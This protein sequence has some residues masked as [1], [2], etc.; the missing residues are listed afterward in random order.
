MIEI[1]HMM[2]DPFSPVPSRNSRFFFDTSGCCHTF[3]FGGCSRVL[4]SC[5]GLGPYIY[6][7]FL[8]V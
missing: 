3:R 8:R 6:I 4:V 1:P 5:G 7:I 2:L